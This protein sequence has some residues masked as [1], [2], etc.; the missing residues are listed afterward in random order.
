MMAPPLSLLGDIREF[1]RGQVAELG[2]W[3]VVFK[4]NKPDS[5]YSTGVKVRK[6]F[7]APVIGASV[8]SLNTMP[9]DLSHDVHDVATLDGYTVPSFAVRLQVRLTPEEDG[10]AERLLERITR[11]GAK[12]FDSIEADIRQCLDDHIRDRLGSA[13]AQSILTS[14]PTRLAF[15]AAEFPL[16]WP[17]VAVTAIQGIDWEEGPLAHDVREAQER[18]IADRAKEHLERD[19]RERH[20]RVQAHQQALDSTLTLS[21]QAFDAELAQR[22][23]QAAID[24]AQALGLDPIAIAE[25]DVW[26]QISQHHSEVL[27][28]LLE[29]QHLYP[30][31]RNSPDLMRAIIDRLG[32]GTGSV[33]LGRQADMVLDG[34]DPQRVL[35]VAGATVHSVKD[36]SEYVEQA[37]LVVDPLI[38]AAWRKAGG[39]SELTGAGYAVAPGRNAALILVVGIP[40]PTLPKSFPDLVRP[41]LPSRPETI[42]VYGAPGS[43]LLDAVKAFVL[44]VSPDARASLVLRRT[45]HQREVLVTLDGPPAATIAVFSTMTNPEN[46]VLPALESLISNRAQIR[47]LQPGV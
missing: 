38:A 22:E 8:A 27:A 35:E 31:L 13:T 25:P 9:Q 42:G 10:A 24:R 33:P 21:Q 28:K 4:N 44:R 43:T 23:L 12:F 39:T 16:Q 17:Y 6:F 40:E 15:P 30:M 14:G 18:D 20:S 47:F 11:D 5:L 2:H 46:P 41:L 1:K 29:S 7:S 26:R 3:L 37:G 34:I 36:S 45:K 19:A 32:G